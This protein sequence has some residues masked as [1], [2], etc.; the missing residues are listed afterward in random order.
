MFL[1]AGLSCWLENW[2]VSTQSIRAKNMDAYTRSEIRVKGIVG[3]R[4]IRGS[5]GWLLFEDGFGPWRYL[6]KIIGTAY[7]NS[8]K[9]RHR[10]WKSRQF[11]CEIYVRRKDVY[12]KEKLSSVC[13]TVFVLN[14]ILSR[15]LVIM[16]VFAIGVIE[17]YQWCSLMTVVISSQMAHKWMF[18]TSG[19]WKVIVFRD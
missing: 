1:C 2:L 19:W 9:I 15:S 12:W 8:N 6:S 17:S 10:Q 4:K 16:V 3:N 13:V 18:C 14:P 5:G 11:L 7:S